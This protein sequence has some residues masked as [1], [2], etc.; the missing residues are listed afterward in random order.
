MQGGVHVLPYGHSFGDDPRRPG[1]LSRFA[2]SDSDLCG[3]VSI[4]A[5]LPGLY[6][7][8]E[9]DEN[10][11]HGHV[12]SFVGSYCCGSSRGRTAPGC[13]QKKKPI[14]S[15]AAPLLS[16]LCLVATSLSPVMIC[17]PRPTCTESSESSSLTWL[18]ECLRCGH[19]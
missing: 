2:G 19:T 10:F 17:S 1:G 5:P 3:E 16:T 14:E 13:G 11:A 6:G 12:A 9:L 18:A 8:V 7:A 15:L 4:R